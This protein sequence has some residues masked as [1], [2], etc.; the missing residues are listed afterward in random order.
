MAS[1]SSVKGCERASVFS[2]MK[3]KTSEALVFGSSYHN[4]VEEFFSSRDNDK[5][6]KASQNYL[7]ESKE[8]EELCKEKEKDYFEEISKNFELL[9]VMLLRLF[10]LFEEKQIEFLDSEMKFEENGIRGFIDGL[11]K[12]EGK[13]Y[14]LEL[15]TAKSIAT[16]H[17]SSDAQLKIYLA[18][19]K[20][21]LGLEVEGVIWIANAKK[22]AY[23]EPVILK[24]GGVSTAKGQYDPNQY[25]KAI[26]QE[27]GCFDN[28]P[29]KVKDFY[30]E[31]IKG[32]N[33]DELI[34]AKLIKFE[35]ES[36]NRLVD[37]FE[38]MAEKR[39][40]FENEVL[41][42]EELSLESKIKLAR[43]FPSS[44]CFMMCQYSEECKQFEDSMAKIT[45]I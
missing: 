26:I 24:K 14:L 22:L 41:N 29:E 38:E 27:Y 39:I 33:P 9:E 12:Y 3:F 28:A 42:N 20:K 37:N 8:F 15:K 19:A 34:S 35:D 21:V 10:K 7:K 43:A 31:I 32:F 25:I 13:L 45:N 6:I 40:K 30:K 5:A 16:S 1:Y 17:L 2:R 23:K 36:I 44:Q 4:G 11:V 18:Y